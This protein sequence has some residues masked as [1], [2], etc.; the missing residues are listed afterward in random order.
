MTERKPVSP[1]DIEQSKRSCSKLRTRWRHACK[2]RKLTASGPPLISS[3]TFSI[4]LRTYVQC[5]TLSVQ[6]HIAP[7]VRSRRRGCL[8][9]QPGP[10]VGCVSCLP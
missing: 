5:T 9:L 4:V 3:L 1:R 6:T 10:L 7:Q 2:G 8:H